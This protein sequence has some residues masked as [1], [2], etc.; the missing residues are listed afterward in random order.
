[1]ATPLREAD[2]VSRL[3]RAGLDHLTF[4]READAVLRDAI[5]YDLAAWA[6]I[7]PV[8]LLVTSCTPIGDDPFAPGHVL[9]TF[10][11]EYLDDEPLTLRALARRDRN[12]GA[13]RSEIDDVGDSL[14]YREILGPAGVHDELMAR[15]VVAGRCWGAVRIYR[16]GDDREP[17][18]AENL[19]RLENVTQSIAEGL[20][21]AFL[22]AATRAAGDLEHPPGMVTV[23]GAGHVTAATE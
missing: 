3:A 15:F 1:M 12:V 22:H 19:E 2:R 16:Y 6:T 7:D 9:R 11:L 10:E 8:T 13:L 18:T 4:Q 17:F 23:D 20:R 21:L 14:R 5:G